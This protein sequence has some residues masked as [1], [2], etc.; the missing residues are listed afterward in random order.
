MYIRRRSLRDNNADQGQPPSFYLLT[1][2]AT[3]SNISPPSVEEPPPSYSTVARS[4]TE[5][6][7]D[8]F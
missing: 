1:N 8:K 4:L 6:N 7:Q 3:D 5:Q 2:N